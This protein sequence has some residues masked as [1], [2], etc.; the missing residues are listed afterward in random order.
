MIQVNIAAER[1]SDGEAWNFATTVIDGEGK[2]VPS[3]ARRRAIGWLTAAAGRGFPLPPTADVEG[4]SEPAAAL[5]AATDVAPLRKAFADLASGSVEGGTI[6][7][8][9][10]YL[11]AV[12]L[13]RGLWEEIS[14][15]AGTEHVELALRWPAG[16]GE[17]SRL[18]WEML[19]C[20]KGYLVR[21]TKPLVAI[22]RVVMPDDGD[23]GDGGDQT[24][25]ISPRVLFVVGADMTDKH[26]RWGTEY[27]GMLRHL[28]REEGG[29]TSKLVVNA[30]PTDIDDAIESFKPSVVHIICHGR[31]DA[32]DDSASLVMRADDDPE[33][34]REQ[35]LSAMQLATRL[36]AAGPPAIV[37]LNACHT[38]EQPASAVAAPMSVALVD[39]GIPLV[40][41]MWGRVADDA[42]RL[43]TRRFY[44]ALL[45][46]EPIV[47]ATARGRR[48]GF[49]SGGDPDLNAD[50]AF[51]AVFL[52]Q[53]VKSDVA[54]SPKARDAA[55]RVE[56]I[57]RSFR[58]HNDP[59]VFC[60]RFDV[61]R[62]ATHVLQP[63]TPD[64]VLVV[65]ETASA[66]DKEDRYGKSRL[67]E[68]LAV[69]AFRE[70]V[71]PVLVAQQLSGNA[72]GNASDLA[73][74]VQRYIT[75]TRDRLEVDTAESA[76]SKVVDQ[77]EEG[78]PPELVERA[79]RYGRLRPSEGGGPPQRVL[80]LAIQTDLER[81]SR[82]ADMSVLLMLDGVDGY[83]PGALALITE[84]LMQPNVL[85]IAKQRV[86]LVVAF[87]ASPS[88][89]AFQQLD[90]ALAQ[91]QR[92]AETTV[93]LQPFRKPW[94]DP[95]PYKQYLL[96]GGR[97]RYVVAQDEEERGTKLLMRFIW[98]RTQGVPSRLNSRHQ[99]NP[100]LQSIVLSFAEEMPDVLKV[101]T[102]DD[103]ARLRQE[104]EP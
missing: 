55:R 84:D 68:E 44:E 66:A 95:L 28:E 56:R 15:F 45:D 80:A 17:L 64:P 23:A 98:D 99:Q 36:V 26:I 90:D 47:V 59:P 74:M 89:Q 51:P 14:R 2:A 38:G 42:C 82:D 52:S 13:G 46:G 94:E 92:A 65:Q 39:A 79:R 43:F 8:F 49:V 87:G 12:L 85:V 10:E 70:N 71:V 19:R 50:W 60:D 100:E 54:S 97:S 96:L 76:I 48:E 102:D 20:S 30:S 72:P 83:G 101:A 81:L 31:I 9:G 34:R 7:A 18:P 73:D 58:E 91:R 104:T 5:C 21:Q 62:A 1:A 4:V 25:V 11:F 35:P 32:S 24:P 88:H 33:R 22:T 86:P 53:R 16:A 41:G 29:L 27:L 3:L 37:V 57:A 75:I 77:P 67:L 61:F 93:N 103:E 78:W 63:T 40:I 6:P 69:Q